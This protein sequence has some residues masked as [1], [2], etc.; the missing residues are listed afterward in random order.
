MAAILVAT[1]MILD[2]ERRTKTNN[3]LL[4]YKA[5][6][7]F[8]EESNQSH[9]KLLHIPVRS[10]NQVCRLIWAIRACVFAIALRAFS[11]FLLPFFHLDLTRSNRLRLE[12]PKRVTV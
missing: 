7:C 8:T 10:P 11:R 2:D 1:S 9:K 4:F 12:L 6:G 3:L 5:S